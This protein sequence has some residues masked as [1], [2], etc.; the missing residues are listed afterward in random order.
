MQR[1]DREWRTSTYSAS[2]VNAFA[3]KV[4]TD[5]GLYGLGA[6]SVMRVAGDTPAG[7]HAVLAETFAPLLL[8][9][10]P[11]AI[12]PIMSTLHAVAAGAHH[13]RCAIDL[14]LHDLKAKTLGVPVYELLGGCFRKEVPVI[15]MVGI[16]EP[17]AQ[18][19][20]A[21]QLVE[22]GYRYLKLKIGTDPVKDVQRVA[23]VR[24]AVGDEVTLTVD[25]NGA[26]DVKTAIQVARKLEQLNVVLFEEPVSVADLDGIAQVTRAVDLPIMGDQTI[27]TPADVVGTIR[28]QAA[29]VVSI[30]VFKVGGLL[31]AQKVRAICE[32][33]SLP[34]HLGSTATT[35][36]IEAASLHFAVA[37]PKNDFGCEIGEYE[38]LDGDLVEGLRVV[39][40][41]LRVP[42][43]PGLGVELAEPARAGAK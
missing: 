27:T 7:H 38:G 37:C 21:A 20:S 28:K 13:P 4:H 41:M 16:K 39:D 40:G 5:E 1:Q 2:T 30:K 3:V 14:A 15:R 32:G 42:E 35:R 9:R 26:Y 33:A 6:T 22:Q 23:E 24:R 19:K 8:G 43:E 17:L 29:D 34:Y 18:A 25:A 11:F 12:E 31:N 36:I 10:D